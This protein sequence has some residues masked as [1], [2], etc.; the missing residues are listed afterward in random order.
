M[1]HSSRVIPYSNEWGPMHWGHLTTEDFIH[2]ERLPAALAPDQSCDAGGCFSGGDFF[3]G[4][5]SKPLSTLYSTSGF[6]SG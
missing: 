6:F 4:F 3:W 5:C 1:S 2:W